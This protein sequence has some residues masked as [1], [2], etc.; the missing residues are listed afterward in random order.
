[1]TNSKISRVHVRDNL[2]FGA[3]YL[4][5]GDVIHNNITKI[6]ETIKQLIWSEKGVLLK[7]EKGGDIAVIFNSYINAVEYSQLEEKTNEKSSS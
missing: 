4:D 5:R 1:M 6:N 3:V 2:A 7:N